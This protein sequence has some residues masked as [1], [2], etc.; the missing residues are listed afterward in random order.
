MNCNCDEFERTYLDG[1][2]LDVSIVEAILDR[3]GAMGSVASQGLGA[4]CRVR[5]RLGWHP[6]A[7]RFPTFLRRVVREHELLL[8]G[9]DPYPPE[10]K[11]ECAAIAATYPPLA[12]QRNREL[13]DPWWRAIDKPRPMI[14]DYYDPDD[15]KRS[16]A[17]YRK[18]DNP[19]SATP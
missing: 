16:I 18:N 19:F 4:R 15:L 9:G 5:A 14:A 7:L 8:N 3:T 12:E 11:A 17:I 10:L 6:Y 1:A 13:N 2:N